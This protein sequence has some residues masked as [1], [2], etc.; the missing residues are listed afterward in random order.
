MEFRVTT[1]LTPI[2]NMEIEGNFREAFKAI[3][4]MMAPFEKMVVTPETIAAAKG[5]RAKIRNMAKQISDYRI[6]T[7]RTWM[8]PME[9]F[10]VKCKA[11]SDICDRAAGNLDQQ[12]K[13]FEDA[14]KQEKDAALRDYYEKLAGEILPYFPFDSIRD[15]RWGNATVSEAAAKKEIEETVR[16][17]QAGLETIRCMES[18]HEAELISTYADTKRLAD[19]VQKRAHLEELDRQEKERRERMEADRAAAKEEESRRPTEPGSGFGSF[20][21]E[22]SLIELVFRV[23]VTEAQMRGLKQYMKENGIKPERV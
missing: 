2:S 22:N 19:V 3:K 6:Q 12:I 4:E 14:R 1:D 7:K 18:P 9:D 8:K 15:K 17:L 13:Q 21:M 11:L 16:Q 10:E 23:R 20:P 5:D